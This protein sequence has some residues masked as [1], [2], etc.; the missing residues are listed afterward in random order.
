MKIIQAGF[1]KLG[2]YLLFA[3]LMQI[4]SFNGFFACFKDVKYW[5]ADKYIT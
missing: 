2:D 5:L 1:L 3:N 4:Q